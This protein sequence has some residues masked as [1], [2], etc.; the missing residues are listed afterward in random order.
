[1]PPNSGMF[2]IASHVVAFLTLSVGAVYDLATTEVPDHLP[3][4]AVVSGILLHAAR[5]LA[6]GNPGP[7]LW[8]V[9][10]GSAYSI[11]GWGLYIAGMWGGADAFSMSALGFAAPYAL[12]GPGMSF[13]VDLFGN[14]MAVGFAYTMA[15]ALYRAA[16]A[17]NVVSGFVKD[18]DENRY[19]IALFLMG[20]A[21]FSAALE[22]SSGSGGMFYFLA[23]TSLL[24]LY[25]FL[26]VIE[27]EALNSEVP[28]EELEPG[29]VVDAEGLDG[30][31]KGITQEEIEELEAE[32][33]VVKTGVRFVPVF[34]V[35][36]ALTDLSV[37]GSGLIV[38][39]LSL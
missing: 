11:Y 16:R 35:A 23:L 33:A 29:D 31:I 4:I 38:F 12:S 21:V 36:L 6:T 3:A 37:G 30:R 7:V 17:G 2:I 27:S 20:S 19:V 9:L 18:L 8:S 26:R 5:S 10:A 1:S 13:P 34:P 15:F 39:I 24:L 22:L 32:S 14:I 25:R 28:V